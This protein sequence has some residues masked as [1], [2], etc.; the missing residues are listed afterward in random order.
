MIK[1]KKSDNHSG[2]SKQKQQS[3][4][5]YFFTDESEV[6]DSD[7]DPNY[8]DEVDA[9]ECSEDENDEYNQET[10][11]LIN[12]DL[13]QPYEIYKLFL[14]DD[15]IQL[16]VTETNR[17]A[18]QCLSYCNNVYTS[19]PLVEELLT[20][21]TFICETLRGNRIGLPMNFKEKK[22]KRDDIF[23]LVNKKGVKNSKVG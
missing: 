1:N 5:Q 14:I 4:Q 16:M 13:T 15:I 20:E 11:M 7:H 2:T 8:T 12:V 3:R 21:K 17:Y 9:F 19:V 10:E 22:M 18:E 6:N 23:S